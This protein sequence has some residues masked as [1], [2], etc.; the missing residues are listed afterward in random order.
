M[1]LTLGE[2]RRGM[3]EILAFAELE[4]FANLKLK[5]YSSGMA[6]RLAY[7][8]A[9]R[10][11]RE[12]LV[13]DEIFAVGDAGFQARCEERYHALRAAGHSVVMVSHDPVVIGTL[14]DRALLLDRRADCAGRGRGR[15]GHRLS[16]GFCRSRVTDT[17]I[18]ASRTQRRSVGRLDRFAMRQNGKASR[19]YAARKGR[20]TRQLRE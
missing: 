6:S 20:V 15:G 10:A 11:V 14:C 4:R 13:L 9:F 19:L 3:D 2:I 16:E 8:V 17:D 5:H 12:V 1:G 18:H 7:A